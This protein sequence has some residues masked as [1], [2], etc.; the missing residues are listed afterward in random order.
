MGR[1]HIRYWDEER[2]ELL[3]QPELF[4]QK[5]GAAIITSMRGY[6]SRRLKSVRYVQAR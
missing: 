1:R 3:N 4:V 2:T 5:S 6:R